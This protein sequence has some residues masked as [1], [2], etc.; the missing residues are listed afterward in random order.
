[1]K[2]NVRMQ[3]SVSV[4]EDGAPYIETMDGKGVER[5]IYKPNEVTKTLVMLLADAIAGLPIVHRELSV[6]EEEYKEIVRKEILEVIAK[7]IKRAKQ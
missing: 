3:I 5:I 2:T 6:T 1:M 7:K 4:G